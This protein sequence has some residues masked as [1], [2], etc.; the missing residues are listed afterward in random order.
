[1]TTLGPNDIADRVLGT[2]VPYDPIA[3][4]L[5]LLQA[6]RGTVDVINP[7]TAVTDAIRM[8]TLRDMQTLAPKIFMD[9][10]WPTA[11]AERGI[12]TPETG[13]TEPTALAALRV[14][15][16]RYLGRRRSFDVLRMMGVKHPSP[17][18]LRDEV[19][20]RIL[21]ALDRSVSPERLHIDHSLV[22]TVSRTT[23]RLMR[24]DGSQ[25]TQLYFGG[26]INVIETAIATRVLG[27]IA[28][29]EDRLMLPILSG[30]DNERL[31]PLLTQGIREVAH[32]LGC[33]EML[34]DDDCQ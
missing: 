34:F 27:V 7:G 9:A 21:D 18:L 16:D 12:E 1:M 22:P 11:L 25:D 23:E 10:W 24:C 3:K 4:N 2:P 28:Q 32:R 20:F 31:G 6:A 33:E 29:R 26:G 8:R 13:K 17:L 5:A 30:D 19:E 14:I 15:S